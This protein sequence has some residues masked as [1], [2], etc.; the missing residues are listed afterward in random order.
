MF[1]VAGTPSQQPSGDELLQQRCL[2][3]WNA[4]TERR[5]FRILESCSQAL[6]QLQSWERPARLWI[7]QIEIVTTEV[8]PVLAPKSEMRNVR[9]DGGSLLTALGSS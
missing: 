5:V 7:R 2:P 8:V 1:V 4:P 3:R 9:I 6:G